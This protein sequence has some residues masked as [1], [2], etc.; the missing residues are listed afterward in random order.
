MTV[1]VLPDGRTQALE[2]LIQISGLIDALPD[3]PDKKAETMMF[4]SSSHWGHIMR[5]IAEKAGGNVPEAFTADMQ[6]TGRFLIGSLLVVNFRTDDAMAVYAANRKWAEQC[7]FDHLR[8]RLKS[9]YVR[10]EKIGVA[11]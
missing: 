2:Q 1:L 10:P 4:V 7:H 6:R 5:E 11:H 9:G 8:E 3:G